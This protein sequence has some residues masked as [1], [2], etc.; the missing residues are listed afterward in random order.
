MKSPWTTGDE[1]R[2]IAGL[3]THSDHGKQLSHGDWVKRYQQTIPLRR[4]WGDMDPVAVR[5]AAKKGGKA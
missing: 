1:I 3:G 5:R 2:F 4:D